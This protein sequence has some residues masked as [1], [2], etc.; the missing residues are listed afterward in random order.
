VGFPFFYI[1]WKKYYQVDKAGGVPSSAIRAVLDRLGMT[2]WYG[3]DGGRTLG[4]PPRGRYTTGS[5][6]AATDA[7]YKGGH[8]R[9]GM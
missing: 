9:N 6:L 2:E 1:G 3:A 5:A 4:S 7:A 8:Y